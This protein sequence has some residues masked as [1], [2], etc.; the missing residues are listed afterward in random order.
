MGGRAR[1]SLSG[2][3][4]ARW[5]IYLVVEN[6]SISTF[7]KW[8]SCLMGLGF[9]ISE[10]GRRGMWQS[11]MMLLYEFGPWWSLGELL[12]LVFWTCWLTQWWI[13]WILLTVWCLL[14]SS[15]VILRFAPEDP[16]VERSSSVLEHGEK[17]RAIRQ[18]SS[19]SLGACPSR[20]IQ[21][22]FQSLGIYVCVPV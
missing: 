13:W 3:E 4:W 5:G 9:V 10:G 12:E 15:W 6:T 8:D 14:G 18:K 22:R 7:G 11:G 20:S 17:A 19:I 1:C 16:T 2:R 21:N